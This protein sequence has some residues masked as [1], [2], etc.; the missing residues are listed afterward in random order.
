MDTQKKL[1]GLQTMEW[2]EL[3]SRLEKFEAAWRTGDPEDLNQF[4]PTSESP[5]RSSTSDT[6]HPTITVKGAGPPSA[7]RLA[8]TVAGSMAC[9]SRPTAAVNDW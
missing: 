7:L 1:D 8:N 5:I 6:S 9:A 4:L 3:Q 2:D